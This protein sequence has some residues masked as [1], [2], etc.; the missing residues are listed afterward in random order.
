[1]FWSLFLITNITNTNF[2]EASNM[3][4]LEDV[5]Y[6]QIQNFQNR[7]SC[8]SYKEQYLGEKKLNIYNERVACLK[9]DE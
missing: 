1:M 6:T 4:T 3:G 9:T 5:R 2:A 8:E 7:Y